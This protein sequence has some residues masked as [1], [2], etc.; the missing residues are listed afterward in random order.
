MKVI[1]AGFPKT[2]TKSLAMALRQL[3]YENV[4]DFEEHL[5]YNLDNYLD[6]FE[7]RADSSIFRKMYSDVDAVVDQPAC[8]LWHIIASQF[9]DAKVILMVRDSDEAWFQSY[10]GMLRYYCEN[11]Q[12]WDHR[13]LHYV[14]PTQNRLNRQHKYDLILSSGNVVSLMY[15]SSLEN[16]S[17]QMFPIL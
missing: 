5:E 11:V 15:I 9:P 16:V 10:S 2:G 6:F 12:P 13:L 8:N 4:H 3:G 1:C 7:G 14:S 17:N